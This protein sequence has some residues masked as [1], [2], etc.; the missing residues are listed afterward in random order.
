MKVLILDSR[1]DEEGYILQE[2]NRDRNGHGSLM[3]DVLLSVNPKANVS[4][5]KIVDGSGTTSNDLLCSGLVHAYFNDYDIVS[6]SLGLRSISDNVGYWLHELADKGVVICVAS[7]NN[8]ISSLATHQATV[9]VGA[10]DEEGNVADYTMDNYDVLAPGYFKG[11]TGT[12]I[13]CAYYAGLLS[14]GGDKNGKD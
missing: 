11:K 4:T 8:A 5:V 14:L 3:L 12:S 6:I 13:A 1:G 2:D 7:G 9:S 10:L